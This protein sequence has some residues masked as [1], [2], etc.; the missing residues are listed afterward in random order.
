MKLTK[1]QRINIRAFVVDNHLSSGLWRRLLPHEE[2][3]CRGVM[4]LEEEDGLYLDVESGE[5][6]LVI[7][8]LYGL[9]RY[10]SVKKILSGD[11][12]ETPE[13]I[14]EHLPYYPL[15]II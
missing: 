13:G 6:L 9:L 3:L 12:I 7:S 5:V 8:V 10:S 4:G 2:Y 14:T 11:Q 1:E 15:K